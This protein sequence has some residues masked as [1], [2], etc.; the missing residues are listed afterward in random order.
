[1]RLL[2][3]SGLLVL[4]LAVYAQ[5]KI[6]KSIS[7]QGA[8]KIR[9]AFEF[10]Q[11]IK[12]HTWDKQDIRITGSV[13]I[14]RGENDD[15]FQLVSKISG[16]TL[17]VVGELK[18]KDNIPRRTIIKKGDQ[19]YYFK[20]NDASDAKVREFLK[21][22]GGDYTYMNNGI[23][24]EITL[25]IFVP[26]GMPCTIDSKFGLVEITDFNAPLTVNAPFGG[27]D[28]TIS[29]GSTG[30]L[31]ARTRFGEIL[32]N[33]DLKF[34]QSR[35]ES[36]HGHWTEINTRLGSGPRYELESKFGKVYLR[37]GK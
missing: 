17:E 24:Q 6:E 19:E 32:T 8:A 2:F 10:T 15:A 23:I 34:D 28:A 7:L 18:D 26:K 36:D 21:E 37:K 11:L 1:M 12:V 4:S 20:A 25:E 13:S 27:I 16:S 9:L 22:N 33:L 3:T 14:N 31:T 30:E 29:H 35:P 5:T